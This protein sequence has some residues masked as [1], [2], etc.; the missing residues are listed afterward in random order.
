MGGPESK[1]RKL[2]T[3]VLIGTVIARSGVTVSSSTNEHESAKFASVAV[4]RRAVLV[5]VCARTDRV[6]IRPLYR[7]LIAYL[8]CF[9]LSA[10]RIMNRIPTNAAPP[11]AMAPAKPPKMVIGAIMAATAPTTYT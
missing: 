3:F 8:K 10:Y 7:H 2:R 4:E 11:E 9:R 5:L 1:A 6:G